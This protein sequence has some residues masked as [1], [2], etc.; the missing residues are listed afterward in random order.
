MRWTR[1]ET[2]ASKPSSSRDRR[3][4]HGLPFAND[5]SFGVAQAPLSPLERFV[6]VIA[7]T[8]S[9]AMIGRFLA[10]V[11]EHVEQKKALVSYVRECADEF[12]FA[13]SEVAVNAADDIGS[14]SIYLTATGTSAEMGDDGQVGRGNRINGL[15]TSSRPMSLEAAAGKNPVS[16]VG[17]I[18]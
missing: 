6:M 2:Y 5:T 17:K 9:C 12:G 13:G 18:L 4:C 3:T 11:Y 8:V 10:D 1:N 15:I 16:H 14:G 7:V